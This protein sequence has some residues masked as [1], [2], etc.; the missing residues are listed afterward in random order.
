[1]RGYRLLK[2]SGR[3]DLIAKVKEALTE[4]EFSLS[5]KDFSPCI[6]GAG[7]SYGEIV[8]RQ[9][10]LIRIGGLNLNQALLHALGK[11]DGKVIFPL[12]K[13]WR[14]TISK[15]GFDVAN[16][17][18]SLLWQIYIF[19]VW[20]Y[21]VLQ[22]AKV[23][24]SGFKSLTQESKKLKRYVYFANLT[25]GNLPYGIHSQKSY[26]IVSWY[27]QWTGRAQS[28]EAVHHSVSNFPNK[29][30]DGVDLVFQT[31]LLPPLFGWKPIAKYTVWSVI[32][33]FIALM[34]CFRGRWWHALLLNQA[35]LSSQVRFLAKSKLAHEYLFH[36]SGW[37]YRPL[38]TYEAE[39]KGS[40]IT[41]YFYSTNCESFKSHNGYQPI[42]YGWKVMSWSRYLVW[43]KYQADF[44][45]RSV[46]GKPNIVNVGPIWFQ[47]ANKK[48]PICKDIK[49]AVFDITP[50]RNSFYYIL[51]LAQEFYT[52]HIVN[53]F[54]EDIVFLAK[55]NYSILWKRKRN[56]G[57]SAHPLY[58]S[59]ASQIAMLENVILI[60]SEISAVNVIAQSDIVISM[61]FTSTALLARFMGKPT[62]YYDA[63]GITQKD[64]RAAHGI[65]I[66][67]GKNELA[68][69]LKYQTKKKS[70]FI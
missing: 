36:N 46:I 70:T 19:G 35:A 62:V 9:Y 22:I 27:L 8:V 57:V 43:D 40:K 26:D 10:L 16:I 61:P 5:A 37:I 17:R 42:P 20:L 7:C 56:V 69:W 41:F 15:Y 14:A 50:H 23:L 59:L 28:V 18:S 24:F 2:Q 60:D 33:S 6:M 66:I 44:I 38:W 13:E 49:I 68:G 45:R 25:S 12:P 63:K 21:G 3:I 58:R 65:D 29:V 54:L 48:M 67:I 53:K 32:S 55:G 30:V 34:E 1:M 51:G 39:K 4:Q 52:P 11:S 47:D 64:D 31:Q